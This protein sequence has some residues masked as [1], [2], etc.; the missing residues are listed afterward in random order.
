MVGEIERV[1]PGDTP[2]RQSGRELARREVVFGATPVEYGD[3]GYSLEDAW[4]RL[5]PSM[6]EW[7]QDHAGDQIVDPHTRRKTVYWYCSVWHEQ[8]SGPGGASVPGGYALTMFG[9]GGLVVSDGST[10]DFVDRPG[11]TRWRNR[12]IALAIDP[13]GIRHDHHREASANLASGAAAGASDDGPGAVLTADLAD[14]DVATWLG[15]LPPVTQRF[16][17]EPFTGSA[18]RASHAWVHAYLDWQGSEVRERHWA[19]LFNS[20]WMGFAFTQRWA[21]ARSARAAERASRKALREAPWSVCA[22]VAPVLRG[23]ESG[24]GA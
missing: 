24:R 2:E 21:S 20:R 1:G 22:W 8:G 17:F 6:R 5:S 4:Q 15:N 10:D 16:L 7:A 13:S 14:S 12:R 9:K 23:G 19:Y 3:P 11:A 18:R